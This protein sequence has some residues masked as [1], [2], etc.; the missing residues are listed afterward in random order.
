MFILTMLEILALIVFEISA[1]FSQV[2]FKTEIY[3][4][5][6]DKYKVA[7][8]IYEDLDTYFGQFAI[9]TGIPK[10]VFT[11]SITVED[12]NRSLH[13]MLTGSL[14]YLTNETAPVPK[15]TYDFTEL[16][17]GI[18]KYIEEYSEENGIEKDEEYYNLINKTISTAEKQ[19]TDRLDVVM[20]YKVAS[21]KFAASVHKY[22]RLVNNIK[23]A[24]AVAMGV[25][26]LLMFFV[27]RHHPR[28][29]TYWIGTVFFCSGAFL[30][31]P[32]LYIKKK[33][34]IGS[35]FMKSEHVYRAVTGLLGSLLDGI[36]KTQII[37]IV[38]GVL[39]IICTLIIHV[40]YKKY[41]RE[42]AKTV[43]V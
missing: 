32:M 33:G 20:L 35:F 30:L 28:D 26:L 2:V 41:L 17:N 39:L 13:S 4:E 9:P 43:N 23:L 37:M 18:T 27:N 15:V 19:I 1:F 10:E 22:P 14:K 42:K 3:E 21:S 40:I 31:I 5:V 38:V 34:Y 36:I 7:E 25:I 8:A 24:S 6:L 16:E 12:I 29:M 11:E